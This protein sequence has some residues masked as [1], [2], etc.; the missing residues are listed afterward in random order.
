MQ[1]Y[2]SFP[3]IVMTITLPKGSNQNVISF[4]Q[5]ELYSK[6]MMARYGHDDHSSSSP[7]YSHYYAGFMQTSSS[8][9][10]VISPPPGAVSACTFTTAKQCLSKSLSF[11][12]FHSSGLWTYYLKMLSPKR[13]F[14]FS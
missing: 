5:L 7:W 8:T 1:R 9:P 2:Y 6:V 3:P 13:T 11:H 4:Q 12:A 14:F 10:H